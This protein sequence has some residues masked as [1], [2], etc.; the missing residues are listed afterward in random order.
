MVYNHY[1]GEFNH[2]WESDGKK[3]PW[4]DWGGAKPSQPGMGLFKSIG[5][6]PQTELKGVMKDAIPY[7]EAAGKLPQET[8][9]KTP[10]HSLFKEVRDTPWGAMPA[11]NK[12]PVKDFVVNSGMMHMDELHFDGLRFD[13]THPIHDQA[14]GGTDGWNM[15]RKLNREIHFFYPNATTSAE[16]FPNHPS[17][18]KPSYADGKGGLGFN[19]MWNTE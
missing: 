16:E 18:T 19:H 2:V 8:S 1:G 7:S 15:L 11:Y 9:A 10:G 5:S 13:F 14:F 3:N 17:I 4:F 6:R 12:K